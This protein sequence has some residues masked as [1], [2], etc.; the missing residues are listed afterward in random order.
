MLVATSI[1]SGGGGAAC[2]CCVCTTAACSSAAKRFAEREQL[3]QRIA[4]QRELLGQ[5]GEAMHLAAGGRRPG[6]LRRRRRASC[7]CAIDRRVEAAEHAGRV[8]G[9][10]LLPAGRRR[11]APPPGA[12]GARPSAGRGLGAEEEQVA[13]EPLG[14]VGVAALQD[15]ELR[16]QARRDAL[17]EDVEARAGRGAAP[18][19]SPRR[20]SRSV[21]TCGCAVPAPRR[22]AELAHLRGRG[23]APACRASA[24][25]GALRA[26]RATVASAWRGTTSGSLV[27]VAPAPVDRPQV[28]RMHALGL[29]QLPAPRGTAGTATAARPCLPASMR[30]R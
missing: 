16:Q 19:T 10:R 7:A 17:G 20:G 9:R 18:R 3:A 5:A 8:V 2:A 25:A 22:G 4:D 24:R 27:D 12:A 14:H 29:D 13:G 6:L 28:G 11:R 15:A 26:R 30:A 21:R 23:R 1:A